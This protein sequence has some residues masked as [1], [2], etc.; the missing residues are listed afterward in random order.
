M[1]NSALNLLALRN[2]LSAPNYKRQILIE[3]LLKK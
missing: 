2:A 3:I 1:Q